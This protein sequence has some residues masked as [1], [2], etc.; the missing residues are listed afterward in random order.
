MAMFFVLLNARNIEIYNIENSK[1]GDVIYFPDN[2]NKV[3]ISW[4]IHYL[5]TMCDVLKYPAIYRIVMAQLEP[6]AKNE[7]WLSYV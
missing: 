5:A 6:T 3:D 1:T 4:Q 2:V 7:T